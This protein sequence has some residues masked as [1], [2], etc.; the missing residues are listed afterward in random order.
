[1]VKSKK[2]KET[3]VSR[4]ATSESRSLKSNDAKRINDVAAVNSTRRELT[5]SSSS[6]HT[7]ET[8]CMDH[9]ET[10]LCA[11]QHIQPVLEIIS[12]Q[13]NVQPSKLKIWDPYYCDGT[14][15]QHLASLGFHHVINENVDFYQ[16]IKV[17]PPVH[18]VLLT[19]PPYSDDHIER[20]LDFVA[21]Q[22][23]KPFC[24]LMP[25]WVARKAEYKS[26][27]KETNM[28]YLSPVVPYTYIMPAWNT[29]PDHIDKA[30][31]ETTPYLSSWYISFGNQKV[32]D[33]ST[34][35]NKLDS[36]SK[37]QTPRVWVV[38]KTIKGLKWKIQK[39]V[40]KKA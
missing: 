30:T 3:V 24:L 11:Y 6:R 15:K 18:D 13:L 38:A 10:P 8:N 35:E 25:N 17:T 9:C 31:G 32:L 34:I 21:K 33:M 37:K 22:H 40:K 16:I 20:L 28:I 39:T 4:V 5:A 29:K 27:M 36:L 12:K 19:N 26:I 1:M 23:N 2:R 14:V 7:F